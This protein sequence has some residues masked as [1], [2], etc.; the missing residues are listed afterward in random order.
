MPRAAAA[1]GAAIF[2][3][4]TIFPCF[5]AVWCY[6]I[7]RVVLFC[8]MFTLPLLTPGINE[9]L[10]VEL[11]DRGAPSAL[12]RQAE[13]H[14]VWSQ[15]ATGTGDVLAWVLV[16]FFLLTLGVI[17]GCIMAL[18]TRPRGPAPEQLLIE[19]VLQNE[20]QLAGSDPAAGAGESWERP[21]DWW[22]KTE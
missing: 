4:R 18:R 2:C 21:A 19:E 8:A 17:A 1:R 10:A 7:Q 15:T 9:V 6:C 3:S 20:D 13:L 5:A 14:R 12:H 16:A 22:R 11:L